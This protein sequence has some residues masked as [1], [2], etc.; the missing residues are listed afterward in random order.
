MQERI[1]SKEK[2]ETNSRHTPS[3]HLITPGR[4]SLCGEIEGSGCA[5]ES[6]FAFDLGAAA[7]SALGSGM[8]SRN[9]ARYVRML[10]RS[11][12]INPKRSCRSLYDLQ[13]VSEVLNTT[14]RQPLTA[15]KKTTHGVCPGAALD[16]DTP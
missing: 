11:G 14:K 2:A 7:E 9:D 12:T 4:A 6:A 13:G 8:R 1:R 10:W 3:E 15:K 5:R 16:P